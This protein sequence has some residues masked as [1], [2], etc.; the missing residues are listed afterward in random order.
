MVAAAR[1][2]SFDGPP[3]WPTALAGYPAVALGA[4]AIVAAALSPAGSRAGFLARPALVYLGRISYGLYVYHVLGLT[5]GKKWAPRGL[6]ISAALRVAMGLAVTVGFAAASYR[7]I[8]GP[9]LKLKSKFA[10]VASR[11]GG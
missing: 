7:F 10:H 4:T 2:G 9:F 8:E 6:A 3:D 1:F 5:L 11:P